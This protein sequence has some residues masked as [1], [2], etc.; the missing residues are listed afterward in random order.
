MSPRRPSRAPLL[1]VAGLLIPGILVSVLLVPTAQAGIPHVFETVDAAFVEGDSAD[2]TTILAQSFV[3]TA[4][5]KLL[6]IEVFAYDFGAS[7]V[8]TVR[9]VPDAGGIPNG[10][11]ITQGQKDGGASYA[12]TRFDLAPQPTLMA[13][14]RYWIEL[15][16][17]ENQPD[18]YRWAKVLNGTYMAGWSEY[19]RGS[20]WITVATQDYMFRTWGVQGPSITVGL[21][22]D[23]SSPGPGDPLVYTVPFDNTGTSPASRVWTNLTLSPDVVYVSDTA[24]ANGGVR[25]SS[26]WAFDNVG[27]GPH[28]FTVTG[29]ASGSGFEGLPM[30]TSVSLQ[31]LDG[32]LLQEPSSAS[33][34]TIARVPSLILASAANPPFVA[35][36]SN[37]SY[38]ITVSNVGSRPAARIWLNDTLPRNVT[39]A[40]DTAS[41]LANYSGQW[42]NGRTIHFNF[43]D[44]VP[45]VYTF[46]IN[47]TVNVGVQ[48]GTGLENWAFANYTDSRGR[49][50]E[51][52][53]ASSV[54]RVNGASIRVAQSTI[55]VSVSPGETVRFTIRFDNDGNA[56]AR[57]VWINDTVPSG[58]TYVS[59]TSASHPAFV[60]GNCLGPS[61]AWY[62]RNVTTGANAIVLTTIVAAVLADGT[63]L[64]NRL[65]LDYTNAD[66]TPLESSSSPASVSV[67]RP[68]FSLS[69][70]A[71]AFANPGDIPAYFIRMDNVGSGLA[72]VAWLDVTA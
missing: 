32:S 12:W 40:Y 39:Y 24:T 7:D 72:V 47:L 58:L 43:T 26:G 51:P 10:A 61:C 35:P 44:V 52:V 27:V 46:A 1:V 9:L 69:V 63:V 5:Y 65:A 56:M 20:N 37:L 53:S 17:G 45:G 19:Y 11:P 3:A 49:V 4:S 66:G 64:T 70:T 55:A 29:R 62:F 33:A 8:A 6:Y 14:T 34:T 57:D 28:S 48:T 60:S 18:G 16:S 23:S 13:G 30:T 41:S 21:A 38:S 25:T 15:V 59:D 68:V 54:A 42:T 67:T 71:N 36:G 22:V 50:R 31:Y 2:K